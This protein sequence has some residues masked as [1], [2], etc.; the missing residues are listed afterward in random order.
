MQVEHEKSIEQDVRGQGLKTETDKSPRNVKAAQN[1][2]QASKR[3]SL[4]PS[5]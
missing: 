2:S 3:N 1:L 5:N 4:K